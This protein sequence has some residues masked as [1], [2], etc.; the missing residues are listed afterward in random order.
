MP[1][2]IRLLNSILI[3]PHVN[4]GVFCVVTAPGSMFVRPPPCLMRSISPWLMWGWVLTLWN[5]LCH[6]KLSARVTPPRNQKHCFQ[7]QRWV[8]HPRMGANITR[9]KYC[10]ALKMAE[11]RPRSDVGNQLATMR[12]LPGNTGD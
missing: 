4:F 12:P 11:A 5:T 3:A 2:S 10:D 7:P 9:E 1:T 6:A 8:I